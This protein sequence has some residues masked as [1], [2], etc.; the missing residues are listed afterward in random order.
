MGTSGKAKVP[1]ETHFSPGSSSPARRVA[2]ARPRIDPYTKGAPSVVGLRAA[3]AR[4]RSS[5]QRSRGGECK[6]LLPD[7]IDQVLEDL[8]G[9]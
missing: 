3:R 6:P 9:S 4:R 5:S 7:E 2:D 8:V 1:A